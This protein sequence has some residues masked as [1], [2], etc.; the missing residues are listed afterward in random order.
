MK[1]ISKEIKQDH[2]KIEQDLIE[3]E[4]ILDEET[5]NY[6]N[7][8]HVLKGL[9]EFWDKHEKKEEKF[10]KSLKAKHYEIPYKKILF[11]HGALGKYF[12]KLKKAFASGSEFEI[13]KTLESVGREMI[14]N[15]RKHMNME[16][17]ILYRLPESLF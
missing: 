13:R 9:F 3:L 2:E 7:L 4:V 14:S 17:E 10:F 16:D 5:L 15:L 12:D 1:D 8:I 6:P 11:E